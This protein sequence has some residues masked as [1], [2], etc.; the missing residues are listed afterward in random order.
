[1]LDRRLL[2]EPTSVCP[3]LLPLRQRF[4]SEAMQAHAAC[5]ACVF[6]EEHQS[7]LALARTPRSAAGTVNQAGTSS[8]ITIIFA[9]W[10]HRY[11]CLSQ[12]L[13]FNQTSKAAASIL[14]C[15]QDSILRLLAPLA[16]DTAYQS[17]RRY[18]FGHTLDCTR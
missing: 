15:T 17:P 18:S 13:S 3:L 2:K 12:D 8:R 14:H 11:P 5:L 16:L 9:D 10:I 1:V 7:L 6:K 4:R